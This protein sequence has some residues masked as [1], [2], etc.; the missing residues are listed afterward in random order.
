[1][2]N[3]IL[4]QQ[5]E[6]LKIPLQREESQDILL[7]VNNHK[8]KL[9]SEYFKPTPW[10]KEFALGRKDDIKKIVSD[11]SLKVLDKDQIINL[12]CLFFKDASI[13][14]SQSANDREPHTPKRSSADKQHLSFGQELDEK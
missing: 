1:M 13:S 4:I 14:G 6:P 7:R 9:Y 11:E 5:E 3:S 8:N 10:E 2:D 12:I